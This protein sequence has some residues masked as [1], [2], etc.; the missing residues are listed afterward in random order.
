MK[1]KVE[2]HNDEAH[3]LITHKGEVHPLIIDIS[4]LERCG[5]FPNTWVISRPGGKQW[6]Q[7][8]LNTEGRRDYVSFYEVFFNGGIP[9]GARL[10][11]K[12]GNTLDFR[13]SNLVF[14]ICGVFGVEWV[15]G[16]KWAAV[17]DR[18]VLVVFNTH[19]EAVAEIGRTLAELTLFFER[20][21]K[22]LD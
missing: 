12:N 11:H 18:T 2:I 17:H 8:Y 5:S 15:E 21:V 1:N 10:A 16:D 14:H 22:N 20:R 4:D 9:K 19:E 6:I 3:I 13:R 7:G